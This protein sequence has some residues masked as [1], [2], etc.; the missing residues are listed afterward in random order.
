MHY[1]IG[2]ISKI[3]GL[4][5]YTLRYYAKEGLLPFVERN[6]QAR[7]QFDDHDL[8]MVNLILLFKRNWNVDKR[9][10]EIYC[11]VHGW[12]LYSRFKT[13]HVSRT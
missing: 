5:S 4:S 13:T 9:N 10:S 3:T 11:V 12:R 2:E 6:D 7:R 1:T 8:S